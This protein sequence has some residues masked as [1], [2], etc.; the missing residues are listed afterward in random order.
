MKMSLQNIE[1]NLKWKEDV[2]KKK[3]FI[4]FFYNTLGY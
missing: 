2:D 1:N 4:T 3:T